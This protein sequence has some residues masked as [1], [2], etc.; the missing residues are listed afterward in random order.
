M[1]KMNEKLW[2]TGTLVYSSTGLAMLF[3]WLL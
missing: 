1:K 2:K 3:F